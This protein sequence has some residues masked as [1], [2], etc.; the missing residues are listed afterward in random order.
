M[1]HVGI[2]NVFVSD[3][4]LIKYLTKKNLD[5]L[6]KSLLKI[7]SHKRFVHIFL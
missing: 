7:T 6:Y 3:R 4:Y 5:N 1:N 2:N